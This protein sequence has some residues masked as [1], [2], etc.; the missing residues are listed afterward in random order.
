MNKQ[1]KL[2]AFA[3]K[4]IV[5]LTDKL[6]VNDGHGRILAFNKYNIIPTDYKFVVNIKNQDPITFGSKCF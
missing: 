6:I 2:E 5:N 4:E 3:A 1:K